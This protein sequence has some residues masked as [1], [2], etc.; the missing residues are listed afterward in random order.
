M[1]LPTGHV[2]LMTQPGELTATSRPPR[3]DFRRYVA[4]VPAYATKGDDV[5]VLVVEDEVPLADAIARGLRREGIAVDVSYDG[6]D[7]LEK[8]M[9]TRYD[10]LV[11]DRDLPVLS[12]D[13]VCRQLAGSGA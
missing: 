5:R 6:G 3:D 13:E 10:V 11:L 4:G 7:A 2:D 1:T 8:A 12:G 9:V